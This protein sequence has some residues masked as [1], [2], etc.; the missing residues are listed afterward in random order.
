MVAKARKSTNSKGKATRE[1][2]GK[3]AGGKVLRGGKTLPTGEREWDIDEIGPI[4][5]LWGK[6]RVKSAKGKTIKKYFIRNEDKHLIWV[7]WSKGFADLKSV[8]WSAEPQGIRYKN[9]L[10][11]GFRQSELISNKLIVFSAKEF[12]KVE[13]IGVNTSRF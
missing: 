10:N 13:L 6:T 9:M 4:Y 8:Y 3:V 2:R 11:C 5:L 7:K 1:I 12:E